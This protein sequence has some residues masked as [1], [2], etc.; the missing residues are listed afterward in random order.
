VA[1]LGVVTLFAVRAALEASAGVAA[2][3]GSLRAVP[4]VVAPVAAGEEVPAAAIVVDER[5]AATV[6]DGDVVSRWA[7]RTAL[8]PLVPGE[9]LLA[10]KVA[11]DGLRGAAAL[12]PDG[13]RALAVPSGLG[14]RPP[15]RV[16]DHVDLL[17][18]TAEVDTVVVAAGALVL[19]VDDDT[20]TVTVAVPAGE[21]PTVTSAI[22]TGA[23]TLALTR[24]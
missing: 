21:A 10:T 6:P 11:P 4:V 18:T 1:L 15:L 2:R 16:G 22:T 24:P 7:G 5:P 9:V 17:A 13:A 23:V 3:Y 8:V 20:D 12:L 14:G 19:H